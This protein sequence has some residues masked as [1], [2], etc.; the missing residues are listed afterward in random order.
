MPNLAAIIQSLPPGLCGIVFRH[1]ASPGRAAL[2]AQIAQI[3]RARRIALVVA[4]DSRLAAALRA[5]LHLRGGRRPGF[6]PLPPRGIV[7]SSAHNHAEL[8]RARRS[9]AQI[10]FCSP[11]FATASHPGAPVL[12]PFGF[13]RIAQHAPPA[14][15]YALGGIDGASIRILGKTCAG[16][17]AIDA[18]LRKVGHGT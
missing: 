3:C 16:A 5:G 18:F 11:V 8:R 13:R 4:G 7:T 2:G 12:G 14:K 1:D 9:G 15:A 6:A 10:I 17:G